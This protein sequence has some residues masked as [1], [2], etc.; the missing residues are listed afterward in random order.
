[1]RRGGGG[2]KVLTA[3]GRGRLLEYDLMGLTCKPCSLRD[4]DGER[5]NLFQSCGGGGR[6]VAVVRALW[7]KEVNMERL[8]EFVYI[9][10]CRYFLSMHYIQSAFG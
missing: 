6:Y 9:P 5:S 3:R 2:S 1:M 7:G 4:G 10:H 8:R